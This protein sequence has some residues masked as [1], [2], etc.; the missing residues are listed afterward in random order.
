MNMQKEKGLKHRLYDCMAQA[1][2]AQRPTAQGTIEYLVII[3]IIIVIALVVSVVM[4]NISSD[5]QLSQTS[6]DLSSNFGSG[7]ISV[8]EAITDADGDALI[9]LQSKSTNPITITKVSTGTTEFSQPHVVTTGESIVIY[10]TDINV[11]C[12]CPVGAKT[13]TCDYTITYTDPAFPNN[14]P[15]TTTITRETIC[16][17]NT[18]PTS[19]EK[20]LG[21]GSGTLTNPWVINS[22][23]E[24]QAMNENL[25]GNYALGGDIN[26]YTETQTA[27]GTLYNSGAGF[28]PV[29]D[30]STPFT[31]NF[32]GRNYT[33]STLYINRPSAD[34]VGL[35]G[36]IGINYAVN[37]AAVKNVGVVSANITGGTYVGGIV[38]ANYLGQITNSYSTGSVAGS[39]AGGI[40]GSNVDGSISNTY[41]T[42]NITGD[43][44]VGGIAGYNTSSITT[45]YNTGNISVS[46]GFAGS[47]GGIIGFSEGGSLTNSYNQGSVVGTYD[48][49]GIIGTNEGVSVTNSY[50]TGSITGSYN[51]G[52]I[53]GNNYGGGSS[54]ASFSTGTIT[55]DTA[56]AALIGL[57]EDGSATSSHWDIYLTGQSNC[58]N[59]SNT[60]C[61]ATNNQASSYYGSS[62]IPFSV[63]G[64]STSI[65]QA[66]D[67][68]YPTLK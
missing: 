45:S 54:V 51:I 13:T 22:C 36:F 33:I 41:H 16:T 10:L 17:T 56:T 44:Q 38:G 4:L 42:G 43:Y 57:N 52:G 60:G 55:G 48:L 15:A 29:G 20:V 12:P 5:Q 25:D 61:T 26:C 11:D 62:G 37:Q 67:N 65:W 59:D 1:P 23:L 28:E 35:F 39:I 40:A 64:W 31:G 50:N 68:N 7:T 8:S 9:T 6:N 14:P 21:L 34:Y 30:D 58:I 32:D 2:T 27:S 47:V 3:A 46:G 66:N 18:T 63:L 19:P 49:G 24:L 53:N